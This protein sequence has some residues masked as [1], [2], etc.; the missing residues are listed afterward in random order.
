MPTRAAQTRGAS[1]EDTSLSGKYLIIGT[2]HIITYQKHETIV[3]V[4]TDSTN[5]PFIPLE[6]SS[7]QYEAIFY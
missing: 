5:K 4:V 2:R 7:D 6:Q 3:E 1:N